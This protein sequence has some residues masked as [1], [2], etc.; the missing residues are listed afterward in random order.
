MD[1][2]TIDDDDEQNDDECFMPDADF[3][4]IEEYATD[5]LSND[6]THID[7][8]NIISTRLNELPSEPPM[9]NSVECQLTPIFMKMK[10][11][12]DKQTGSTI[13]RTRA[14]IDNLLLSITCI[15]IQ[16]FTI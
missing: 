12:I 4:D 11:T 3:S 14:L 16:Q 6:N 5:S 1:I 10:E 2:E 7:N 13:K 8:E 9:T 15:W